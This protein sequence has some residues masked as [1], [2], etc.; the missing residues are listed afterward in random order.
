MPR[1]G[2]LQMLNGHLLGP[3]QILTSPELCNRSEDS[4]HIAHAE[5]LAGVDVPLEDE[6]K[7]LSSPGPCHC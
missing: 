1:R 4:F 6:V 2:I 5:P 7:S 3:Q